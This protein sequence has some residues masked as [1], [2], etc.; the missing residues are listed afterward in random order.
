MREEA[1]AEK[2]IIHLSCVD[3]GEAITKVGI[4]HTF[5][6]RFYWETARYEL[7]SEGRAGPLQRSI[8][9]LMRHTTTEARE[10]TGHDE[11]R[12]L[13]ELPHGCSM[14]TKIIVVTEEE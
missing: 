1:M 5:E 9:R 6:G 11:I 12:S 2:Y 3:G 8:D 7:D 14:P 13:A 4:A 10:V